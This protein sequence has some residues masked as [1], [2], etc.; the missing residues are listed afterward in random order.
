MIVRPG[1]YFLKKAIEFDYLIL[2][3]KES[4]LSYRVIGKDLMRSLE[5]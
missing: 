2:E 3:I 4:L 5:G 1:D